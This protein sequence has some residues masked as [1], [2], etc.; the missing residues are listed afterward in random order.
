M[1]LLL[2]SYNGSQL[3]AVINSLNFPTVVNGDNTTVS[4]SVNINGGKEFK[5]DVNK[6]LT[7]MIL[8]YL[9]I[10]PL[11][12]AILNIWLKSLQ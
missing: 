8:L 2:M 7:N 12:G 10:L 5:V 9:K 6:N 4:E 11:A 1:Q 3:N